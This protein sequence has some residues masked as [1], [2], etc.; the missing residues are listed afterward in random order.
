MKTTDQ[1]QEQTLSKHSC[2]QPAGG[3]KEESAISYKAQPA[4]TNE[5]QTPSS[6][7]AGMSPACSGKCA[8][9]FLSADEVADSQRAS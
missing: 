1:G 3:D 2:D 6:T 9:I 8:K 7:D 4:I 5:A